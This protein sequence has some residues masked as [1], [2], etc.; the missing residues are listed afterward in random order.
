MHLVVL[1]LESLL[2]SGQNV[3]SN[4]ISLAPPP[5]RGDLFHYTYLQRNDLGRNSRIRITEKVVA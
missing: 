3:H 4:K 2:A 5:R 1:H